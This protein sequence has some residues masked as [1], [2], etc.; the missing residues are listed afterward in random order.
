MKSIIKYNS[1]NIFDNRAF[2]VLSVGVL[3]FIVKFDFVSL[4]KFQ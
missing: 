1:K 2:F 4:V 3:K